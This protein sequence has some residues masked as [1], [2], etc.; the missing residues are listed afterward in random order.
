MAQQGSGVPGIAV[1]MAGIAALLI[2]AG[3]QG[4]D[5]LTALRDVATGKPKGLADR[6]SMHEALYEGIGA[7]S[8]DA[9]SGGAAQASLSSVAVS[10]PHPEFVTAAGHHADEVYSKLKRWQA[11]YSDCSSFAGK[12]L[13]D[14]GITPPGA[15]T[16]SSYL[17]WRQ[18][19][20][21]ARGDIG[22]GDFLVSSGHMAIAINNTMAI[23]QQREGRNVQVGPISSIM[24]G[25]SWVA[26]RYTGTSGKRSAQA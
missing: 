18:A 7:P 24:W 11:G 25:Q 22:A 17:A 13:K 23:G 19:K 21:V 3:F 5:P 26:L 8:G 1:G 14:C 16:T 4:T 6:A 9:G 15:S 2:Y 12:A 20:P 10:G